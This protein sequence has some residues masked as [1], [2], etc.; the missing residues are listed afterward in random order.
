MSSSRAR[1][2]GRSRGRRAAGLAWTAF[3]LS[4]AAAA[5]ALAGVESSCTP[6]G[7]FEV[8]AAP[9]VAACLKAGAHYLDLGGGGRCS[10]T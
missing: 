6:Q 1:P 10:W 2:T 8:T 7:R 5:R 4:D 9:M 3:E